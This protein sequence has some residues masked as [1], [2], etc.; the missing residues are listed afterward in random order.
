M[1]HCWKPVEKSTWYRKGF[2]L[3][4]MRIC[5]MEWG[6]QNGLLFAGPVRISLGE[7]TWPITRGFSA[8]Q[9]N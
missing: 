4:R 2:A 5:L 9:L 7:K 3:D 8:E 1:V 6:I